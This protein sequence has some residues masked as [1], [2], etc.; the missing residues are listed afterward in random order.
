MIFYA[1]FTDKY[2]S[3]GD[4]FVFTF[5]LAVSELNSVRW[6]SRRLALSLY[7]YI[8][9]ASIAIFWE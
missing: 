3:C 9:G 1:K 6:T 5:I 8:P 7:E 4:V 2:V